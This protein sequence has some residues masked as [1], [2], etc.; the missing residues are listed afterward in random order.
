MAEQ[1]TAG[2][3]FILKSVP[4]EWSAGRRRKEAAVDALFVFLFTAGAGGGVLSLFGVTA[5]SAALLTAA[6]I[7]G[8]PG[9]AFVCREEEGS[10]QAG[11]ASVGGCSGGLGCDPVPDRG[12]PGR[13]EPGFEPG[14]GYSGESFPVSVSGVRGQ[15]AGKPAAASADGGASVGGG[16]AGSLRRLSGA[17]G[18]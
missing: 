11:R 16:A 4:Q 3:N 5:H 18:K 17:L 12:L 9:L 6:V 13:L 1:K 7:F 10:G 14:G 8:F 15:R 2:K